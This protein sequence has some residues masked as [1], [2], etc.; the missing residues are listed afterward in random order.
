MDYFNNIT[1][2]NE[3]KLIYRRLAMLNHPDLGG[4]PEVMTKINIEYKGLKRSLETSEVNKLQLNPGD[5]VKINGSKSLVISVSR[6]TFIARSNITNR[7]AV[8]NLKTGICLSN[9][10]FKAEIQKSI[11]NVS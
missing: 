5:Y 7:Q 2:I 6:N 9:P 10:K 11:S 8:F 3:A 4:N 1:N